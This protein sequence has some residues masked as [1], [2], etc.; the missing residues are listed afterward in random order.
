MPL[1]STD[2]K[3]QKF[4]QH[5][6][7]YVS[8]LNLLVDQL[9]AGLTPDFLTGLQLEWVSAT[10][11]NVK[12]GSA[13]VS[14]TGRLK[15][16]A[17][18]AKTALALGANAWGHVY[19]YSNAGVATVEVVTTA[20]VS[21]GFGAAYQ[22]TGDATRRY[23]GSVRTDA[24]GNILN[25][26][27]YDGNRIRYRANVNN[28][29]VLNAG[30]AT[31]ET[32]V[33]CASFVPVTSRVAFLHLQNT[34]TNATDLWVGAGSGASDDSVTPPTSGLAVVGTGGQKGWVGEVPLNASQQFSYAY[35][36][37]APTGGGAYCY[38]YGYHFDR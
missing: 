5:K 25:F 20:P 18:I 4:E 2:N 10:A 32:N 28:M 22:K 35:G 17:T 36:P 30:V 33:S 37:L 26:Y 31:G 9:D 24:S 27:H 7:D 38:V 3:L 12:P 8:R 6:A 21:A 1:E 23:L 34:G 11:I 19:L 29:L 16:A 14:G 13:W 15:V